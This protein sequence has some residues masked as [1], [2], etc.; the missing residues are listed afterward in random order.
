MLKISIMKGLRPCRLPEIRE[1]MM[2]ES[3]LGINNLPLRRKLYLMKDCSSGRKTS[4]EI[5]REIHSQSNVLPLI[6][7]D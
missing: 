7:S 2:K 3:M 1:M 6:R 4:G 5:V